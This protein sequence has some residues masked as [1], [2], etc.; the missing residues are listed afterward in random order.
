[1]QAVAFVLDHVSVTDWPSVMGVVGATVSVTVGGGVP[2]LPPGLTVP[3]ADSVSA[4]QTSIVRK[5][6]RTE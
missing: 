6:Y 3:Q 4:P 2:P 1:M 5:R